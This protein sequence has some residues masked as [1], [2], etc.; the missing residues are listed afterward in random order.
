M[1]AKH[2]IFTSCLLVVSSS[3]FANFSDFWPFH[4]PQTIKV[5][6]GTDWDDLNEAQQRALLKRYQEL[7]ELPE[8]D[9]N[10]L[11]QRMEWFTQLSEQDQQKMRDTW[12]KMSSQERNDLRKRM[13][14]AAPEQRTAIRLEYIQKHEAE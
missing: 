10:T 9:S 6:Y 8:S 1:V 12:Q 5:N 11:Q 14:K 3:C 7:K 13:N 4:K 2:F